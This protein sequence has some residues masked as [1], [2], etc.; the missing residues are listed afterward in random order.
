MRNLAV[1]F[2][3]IIVVCGVALAGDPQPLSDKPHE[4]LGLDTPTPLPT[5]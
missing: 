2:F 1:A 3:V 4:V 5:N